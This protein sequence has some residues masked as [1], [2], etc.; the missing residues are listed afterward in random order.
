MKGA[1]SKGERVEPWSATFSFR[2]MPKDE[3][4]EK[5]S[6]IKK[7][8]DHEAKTMRVAGH[9]MGLE[10]LAPREIQTTTSVQMRA[11]RI[12]LDWKISVRKEMIELG[13]DLLTKAHQ[14][15]SDDPAL[16]GVLASIIE[17]RGLHAYGE[18]FELHGKF[19]QKYDLK[20]SKDIE[21]KMGELIR[22]DER[23][24][25]PYTEH[26]KERICPLPHAT[27]NIL[28]HL[29]TN[30]NQLKEDGSDITTS[31]ALLKSWIG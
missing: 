16:S 7:A 29:G 12:P 13:R 10:I 15:G 19:V 31:I 9:T 27:R 4:S 23:Y 5:F 3:W 25:R 30:P 17:G 8:G 26:G 24:L 14:I 2:V 1:A 11:A 21:S 28:A 18:F 6:E 22:N 20:K